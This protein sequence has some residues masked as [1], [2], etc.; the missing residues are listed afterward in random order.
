AE[1]GEVRHLYGQ[2]YRLG[3][4]GSEIYLLKALEPLDRP[5][6]RVRGAGVQLHEILSRGRAGV[7]DVDADVEGVVGVQLLMVHLDVGVLESGIAQPEPEWVGAGPV[8]VHV[9]GAG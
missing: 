5:L 8:E 1:E 6:E 7:G 9:G 3:L 2:S 4:S